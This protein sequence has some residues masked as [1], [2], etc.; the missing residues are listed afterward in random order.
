MNRRFASSIAVALA[1]ATAVAAGLAEAQ[2]TSL[3]IE[4]LMTYQAPL[5]PGYAIDS[6]LIIV[7]VRPGGWAKGP[8]IS[9]TFVT[10]GG[11]WIRLLPSGA[12]RL[13][14]RGTL[15]TD[16]G[17]LIFISYNGIIRHSKESAERLSRGEVLTTKD[18]PYFVTAPTFETSSPKYAW[19][20]GVQAINKLVELKTGEGGYV[21]YDV[22]V[23]R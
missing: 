15:K 5:D 16:D 20:N 17:A 22:F 3:N 8:K 14:V 9:G 21:R 6:S 4:Y 10:P 18:I 19:L 1:T 2:T 23:V 7:G 11:D 13:D 12:F